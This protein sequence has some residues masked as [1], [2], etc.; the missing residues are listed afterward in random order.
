MK[1]GD[2]VKWAKPGDA[3]AASERFVLVEHDGT[4]GVVRGLGGGAAAST[5]DVPLADLALAEN[6][7][8]VVEPADD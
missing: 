4:R 5:R 2:K 7:P 1:V 6:A 3:A 8:A